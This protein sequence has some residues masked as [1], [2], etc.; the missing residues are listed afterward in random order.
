MGVHARQGN[1]RAAKLLPLAGVEEADLADAALLSSLAD[2]T[3]EGRSIVTLG[4][5]RYGLAPRELDDAVLVPFTAETRMSGVDLPAPGG[6]VR[7]V[8]KGAVDS[9]RRW[10]GEQGGSA[11]GDLD[12]IA[13]GIAAAG[14]KPLAVADGL[15]A[16]CRPDGRT[17]MA[18]RPGRVA[19]SG[20]LAQ[21]VRAAGLQPKRAERHA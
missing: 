20:R 5:E 21:L 11:P 3:P 14:G 7:S 8:R 18:K 10:V 9:V 17:S 2:D 4:E 13:D 19:F 6:T 12:P 1:G 15:P 16:L